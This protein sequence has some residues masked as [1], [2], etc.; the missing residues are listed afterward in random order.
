MQYIE[1]YLKKFKKNSF[2]KFKFKFV[3]TTTKRKLLSPPDKR[4]NDY[5]CQIIN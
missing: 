1:H 3:A 4:Q 5:S 2:F